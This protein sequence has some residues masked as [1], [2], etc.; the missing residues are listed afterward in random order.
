MVLNKYSAGLLTLLGTVVFALQTAYSDGIISSKEA[1]EIGGLFAGTVATIFVP[2][3]KGNWASSLK[4]GSAIALAL[5][6]VVLGQVTTGGG[7]SDSTTMTLIFAGVNALLAQLGIYMRLDDVKQ[8]LADVT[9]PVTAVEALDA[10]AVAVAVAQNAEINH[11][12]DEIIQGRLGNDALVD[13]TPIY[14]QVEDTHDERDKNTT[15]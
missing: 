15:D 5:I 12:A 8:A 10:P 1:W 6:G 9:K 7:W 4:I 3:L 11:V 13:A 2:L 14:A